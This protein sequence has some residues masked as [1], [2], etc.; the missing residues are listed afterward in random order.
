MPRAVCVAEP[1][2]GSWVCEGGARTCTSHLAAERGRVVVV[3]A[4]R[5]KMAR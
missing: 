3:G 5:V 4:V 2:P 1:P